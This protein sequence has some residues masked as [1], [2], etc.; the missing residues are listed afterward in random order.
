LDD[1]LG[2][3]RWIKIYATWHEKG[4]IGTWIVLT[5]YRGG[6]LKQLEKVLQDYKVNIT[7]LQEIH[8]IGQGVLEKRTAVCTTAVRKV[9]MNL[10][11][12]S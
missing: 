8:W 4:R 5:L 1:S 12:D 11:A 10:D 6:A 2:D 7:A 9:S 3:I